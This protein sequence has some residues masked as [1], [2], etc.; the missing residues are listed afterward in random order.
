MN[1]VTP[2]VDRKSAHN[3][4]IILV[5]SCHFP[6]FFFDDRNRIHSTRKISW[7][8]VIQYWCLKLF[9]SRY[10]I[11]YTCFAMPPWDMLHMHAT[12]VFQGSFDSFFLTFQQFV[13]QYINLSTLPYCQHRNNYKI[14]HGTAGCMP[15]RRAYLISGCALVKLNCIYK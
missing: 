10:E 8:F 15:F 6:F 4:S 5:T 3:G 13:C 9:N 7:F 12:H 14:S 2:Q 11:R 1:T